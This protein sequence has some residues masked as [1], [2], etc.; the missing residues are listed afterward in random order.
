VKAA[1]YAPSREAATAGATNSSSQRQAL[2]LALWQLAR[3]FN[4][5][6]YAIRPVDGGR[7]RTASALPAVGPG[8]FF[9]FAMSKG[10]GAGGKGKGSDAA[11]SGAY[12]QSVASLAEADAFE[13]PE[14]NAAKLPAFAARPQRRPR[15]PCPRSDSLHRPL[16]FT[17][18]C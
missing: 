18:A 7:T 17:P 9:L 4:H 12:L 3:E 2:V 5:K 11:S 1:R 13:T 14:G 16:P 6:Y 8:L 10:K 15:P